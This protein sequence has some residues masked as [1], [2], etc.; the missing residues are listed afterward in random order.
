MYKNHDGR[1]VINI[2]MQ[3]LKTL[4]FYHNNSESSQN[5]LKYL[6]ETKSSCS[7]VIEKQ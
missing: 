2:L 6:N 3:N 7:K 1:E 4:V 5:V